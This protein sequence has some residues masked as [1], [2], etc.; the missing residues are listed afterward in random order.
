MTPQRG[1]EGGS[2]QAGGR[3]GTL[4]RSSRE[5]RRSG[6][7]QASQRQ[8][9]VWLAGGL[10][11]IL[12]SFFRHSTACLGG[13]VLLVK[14]K[15]AIWPCLPA[16]IPACLLLVVMVMMVPCSLRLPPPPLCVPLS[17][18]P[19]WVVSLVVV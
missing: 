9:N 14:N 8:L 16:C 2:R 6:N 10:R 12:L 7:Q 1:L 3:A 11:V 5:G 17:L 15:G 13:W 18:F 19:V 4:A